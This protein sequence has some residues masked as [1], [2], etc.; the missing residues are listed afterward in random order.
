MEAIMN[1]RKVLPRNPVPTFAERLCR[2]LG[3]LLLPL[4]YLGSL[5]VARAADYEFTLLEGRDSKVCKAY[6]AR[7]NQTKFQDAPFCDRPENSSVPGF[8]GLNRVA[9]APSAAFQLFPSV[10]SLLRPAVEVSGWSLEAA[11]KELGT[12]ILAWE[13][14]P[15]V[16]IENNGS[17]R[18]LMLWRGNRETYGIESSDFACGYWD[19]RTAQLAFILDA[20]QSQVDVSA[21]KSVFWR[22]LPAIYGKF[23]EYSTYLPG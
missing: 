3:F 13:Y 12:S 9:L 19:R 18:T 23:K 15:K 17:S 10:A 5:A 8:T 6:L 7:L 14:E 21:T 1:H 20:S 11:K 4:F 22:A 16:D 2:N